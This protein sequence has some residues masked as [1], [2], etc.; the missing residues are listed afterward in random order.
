LTEALQTQSNSNGTGFIIKLTN[1]GT[2]IFYSTYF[3]GVL[4]SVSGLG[5]DAKGN[6]YVTGLTSASDFPQTPGLPTI[7][8]TPTGAVFVAE[9]PA[10]GGKILYSGTLVPTGNTVFATYPA[11][12]G[13][14]VDLEDPLPYAC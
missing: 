11:S 1:D 3:G 4:S 8:L 2:T 13:I 5:T 10:A 12:S 7:S 14:A 9:I 6:L